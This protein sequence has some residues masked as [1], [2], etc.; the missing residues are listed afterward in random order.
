MP[1]EIP[2]PSGFFKKSSH[3]LP[4]ISAKEMKHGN[5]YVGSLV[6]DAV[7]NKNTRKNHSRIKMALFFSFP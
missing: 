6:L 4:T 5:I 7:K 3:N 2:R 1:S